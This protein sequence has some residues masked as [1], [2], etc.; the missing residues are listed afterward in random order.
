MN[1]LVIL[2]QI[3]LINTLNVLKISESKDKIPKIVI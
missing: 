1:T 2:F 3:L